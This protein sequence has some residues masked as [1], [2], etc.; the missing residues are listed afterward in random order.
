MELEDSLLNGPEQVENQTLTDNELA[1]NLLLLENDTEESASKNFMEFE[2]SKTNNATDEDFPSYQEIQ[3]RG[4][5]NPD[6]PTQNGTRNPPTEIEKNDTQASQSQLRTEMT[7]EYGH[8]ENTGAAKN[9]QTLNPE[10]KD[11]R[12]INTRKYTRNNIE[13]EETQNTP[14]KVTNRIKELELELDIEILKAKL[15]TKMNELKEEYFV[16]LSIVIVCIVYLL[17]VNVVNLDCQNSK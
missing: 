2:T 4:Q 7:E 14:I 5:A 13:P 16:I 11:F 15:E 17:I 1:E 10:A 9:E 8:N 12:P 6:N 3:S